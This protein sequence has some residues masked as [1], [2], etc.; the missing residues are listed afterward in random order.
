M[1]EAR[2]PLADLA[3]P[4]RE[5]LADG[6]A[7][8][9]ISERRPGSIV[10]VGFWPNGAAAVSAALRGVLSCDGLPDIGRA[11]AQ[12]GSFAMRLAPGRL[13]AVC[14]APD[15]AAELESAL[16]ATAGAVA[17]VSDGRAGVRIAG[18]RARTVLQKGIAI[19]L[20]PSAFTPLSVVQTGIHHMGATVLR[21]DAETF[22][23][24]V[25]R[26][27]ARS[28]WDWLTE[29]GG[30]MRL[31]SRRP[32]RV[33]HPNSPR[34]RHCRASPGNP[35]AAAT[36][37][38]VDWMPGTSPGTTAAGSVWH[39]PVP[40]ARPAEGR[41]PGARNFRRNTAPRAIDEVMLM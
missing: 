9:A 26:G 7:G 25:L 37:R 41:R 20:D 31:E 5:R 15:I 2:F 40:P 21:L 18:P 23:V 14:Q 1:D 8:V 24:F 35:L 10:E 39:R 6:F 4:G 16:P 29:F 3:T 34:R 28:F 17:N 33:T 32:S 19:D 22:D 38:S 36:R 12:P 11:S 13:M 27:F 30:R